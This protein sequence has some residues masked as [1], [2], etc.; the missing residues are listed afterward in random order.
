MKKHLFIIGLLLT[1]TACSTQAPV[2]SE[3]RALLSF[4]DLATEITVGY[5]ELEKNPTGHVD[6]FV[7]IGTP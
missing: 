5:E 6:T 4:S 7:P 1:Q 3:Q 2:A